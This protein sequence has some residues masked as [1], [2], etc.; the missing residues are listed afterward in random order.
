MVF[1]CCKNIIQKKD[2]TR[3]TQVY[4]KINGFRN[5]LR[6]AR[7]SRMKKMSRLR[8]NFSGTIGTLDGSNMDFI[9]EK[10]SIELGNKNTK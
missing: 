3:T 9:A 2:K 8:V 10:I 6:W 5:M 7:I 4:S 1:F